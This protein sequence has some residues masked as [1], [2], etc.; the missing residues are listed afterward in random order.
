V[1]HFEFHRE[2]TTKSGLLRNLREFCEESN[3]NYQDYT[4]LTFTLNLKEKG[5]ESDLYNFLEFF[6]KY[7][8]AKFFTG[9]KHIE[10]KKKYKRVEF[11]KKGGGAG[12]NNNASIPLGI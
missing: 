10:I 2:L 9:K 6:L 3:K 7:Q 4:P 11:D 8:P 5:W 12:V 1:N